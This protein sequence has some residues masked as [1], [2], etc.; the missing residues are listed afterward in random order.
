MVLLDFAGGFFPPPNA[1]RPF[2]KAIR[3]PSEQKAVLP[4]EYDVFC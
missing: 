1:E 3:T 2:S 4:A